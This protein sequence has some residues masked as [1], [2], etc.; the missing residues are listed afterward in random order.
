MKF[1][2]ILL[3]YVRAQHNG[4]PSTSQVVGHGEIWGNGPFGLVKLLPQVDREGERLVVLPKLGI[5]SE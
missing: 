1:R 5:N 4:S 2:A 3:P